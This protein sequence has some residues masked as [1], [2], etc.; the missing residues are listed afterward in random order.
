[1][2]FVDEG[3]SIRDLY[4][5]DDKGKRPIDRDS[6]PSSATSSGSRPVNPAHF[7]YLNHRVLG[8]S[9]ALKNRGRSQDL[10]RSTLVSILSPTAY[11]SQLLSLILDSAVLDNAGKNA[12]SFHSHNLWLA[13][14]ATRTE[15]SSTLLYAIRAISLSFLGCQT[16]DENLVQN[17]RLI[18]GKTL[19]KLNKS[20]QDP[21]EGLSSD[22]LSATVL[23]TFYEMLNCTE[24]IS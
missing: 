18:Y 16:R 4:K 8:T 6:S 23:L 14:L 10:E 21:L 19:L 1:M 13:Q 11:Q 2:S 12:P 7:V 20:L 17:S 3:P 9:P 5:I 15:V 24:K 22:T